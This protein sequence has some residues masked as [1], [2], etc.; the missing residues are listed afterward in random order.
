MVTI[1]DAMMDVD[2]FIGADQSAVGAMNRPLHVILFICII[3]SLQAMGAGDGPRYR[4][5]CDQGDGTQHK[6]D[7]GQYANSRL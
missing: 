5:E 6:K 4:L 1:V 2:K 7:Q 3:G